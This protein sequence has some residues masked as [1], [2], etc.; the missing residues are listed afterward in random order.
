MRPYPNILN[1]LR[2]TAWASTPETIEAVRS[3]LE[4]HPASGGQTDS[5]PIIDRRAAEFFGENDK[6]KPYV[7]IDGVALVPFFG[8][9]GKH[10][11]GIEVMCGGLDIDRF[12]ETL[13]MAAGDEEAINGVVI[14]F[15]SPGGIVTG[16]PEAAFEIKALAQTVP[17]FAYTDSIMASAAYWL[18]S[19]TRNV[20]AAPSSDVG[21]IGVYL[22]WMDMSEHLE[23]NGIRLELIKAGE[24]KAVGHPAVRISDEQREMLQSEV[25][26]I[27]A[28]FTGA[29]LNQRPSV[30]EESMQG[31]TF[32]F[33]AQVSSNLV[34][35]Q[36]DRIR[37]LVTEI[38]EA[39]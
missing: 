5:E 10:L 35:D 13:R 32:S 37:D 24:H 33:D 25:D 1:R 29:V 2:R 15:H 38:A 11:D 6:R 7:I 17:I 18:A 19:Q 12:M 30:S 3:L 34:D 39:E 14:W 23:E 28:R 4:R 36:F 26:D 21:S 31:Q 9:V 20:F 8:V 22:S 16:I 27:Y